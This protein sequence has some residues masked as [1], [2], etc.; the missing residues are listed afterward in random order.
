MN[1]SE[2]Q[3]IELLNPSP[4]IFISGEELEL[5]WIAPVSCAVTGCV[6]VA[7]APESLEYQ[8]VI[9][10]ESQVGPCTLILPWFVGDTVVVGHAAKPLNQGMDRGC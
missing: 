7:L 6:S 4:E 1:L 9:F 2:S 10:D 8:P 5:L 3:S